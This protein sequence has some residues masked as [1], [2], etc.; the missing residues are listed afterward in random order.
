MLSADVQVPA[1]VITGRG[2]KYAPAKLPSWCNGLPEPICRYDV[3]PKVFYFSKADLSYLNVLFNSV[4]FPL[5]G[6]N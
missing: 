6:S 5:I 2:L 4:S 3:F 1:F